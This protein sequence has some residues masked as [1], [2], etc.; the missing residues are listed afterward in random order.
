[1][2]RYLSY[3]LIVLTYFSNTLFSCTGI[4]LTTQTGSPIYARTMD[5]PLALNS[6]I[7]FV[8][9]KYRFIGTN[10]LG[11]PK[12]LGWKSKYAVI[13]ANALNKIGF[14]DGVNEKGLAG[15]LFY[16]PGTIYENIEENDYKNSLA[17]HEL[18]TWILTRF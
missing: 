14:V 17:A 13:G 3:A 9:R 4:R 5:F 8:P 6:E 2:N 16:L 12:G 7:L 15:G 18:L 11:K 1:M 10:P